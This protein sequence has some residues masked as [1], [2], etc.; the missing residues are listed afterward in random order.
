MV[1][2]GAMTNLYRGEWIDPQTRRSVSLSIS[3]FIFLSQLAQITVMSYPV[4]DYLFLF[5]R[6]SYLFTHSLSPS[7]LWISP[8][9]I[10]TTPSPGHIYYRQL[11]MKTP[12]VFPLESLWII[13]MPYATCPAL[14]YDSCFPSHDS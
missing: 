3:S 12:I 8:M 9:R 1:N 13:P 11:A 4:M 6:L 14:P 2:Y 10:T 5:F 7:L